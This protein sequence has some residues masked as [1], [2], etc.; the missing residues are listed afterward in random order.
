MR[1]IILITLFIIALILMFLAIVFFINALQE[2][3]Y[4]YNI[5]SPDLL[6]RLS[7]LHESSMRLLHSILLFTILIIV[8]STLILVVIELSFQVINIEI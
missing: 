3:R 5:D 6:E 1:A 2:I 4:V 8:A 7:R